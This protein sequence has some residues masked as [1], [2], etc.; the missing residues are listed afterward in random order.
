M[1]IVIDANALSVVLDPGNQNHEEFKPV[2][3]WI[4]SGRGKM[5]YGGTRYENE[6]SRMRGLLGLIVE[7]KKRGST[8][9]LERDSVDEMED[10]IARAVGDSRFNDPHILAIVIVGRCRFVCS[11]D[12]GLHKFL[13]DRSLYP[14]NLP[15]AK[16]YAGLS[17]AGILR[18]R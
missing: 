17:S 16:I 8:I 13:Q 2:F 18:S 7:L 15:T 6:L 9:V 10:T 1:R 12:K 4:F 5:T 14:K 3:D 11:V